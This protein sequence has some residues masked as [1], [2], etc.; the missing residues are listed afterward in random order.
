MGAGLLAAPILRHADN[1]C[2]F[3][4][5]ADVH[6]GLALDTERRLEAFVEEASRRE[7]DFIVQLG[8]FNH[9]VRAAR[10]FIDKWMAYR[11]PRYGVLGNHDMDMGSKSHALDL[12]QLPQRYYS[13]DVGGRHFVVLDANNI[14]QDRRFVHYAD[15]NYFQ[16][17]GNTDSHCDDEQLDW[18]AADLA[19]TKTQT[20]VF[21]HQPIDETYKG[22]T[23]R[24]RHRVRAILEEANQRA[25]RQKVVACFAGH[26]HD[27]GYEERRDIHYFRVNSASYLWVG[28]DYGRM[29]HY[30]RSLFT[31]VTVSDDEITVEGRDAS[32]VSPEPSERGV[33]DA[34]HFVPRILPRRVAIGNG[35]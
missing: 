4:V 6:H 30:D 3:G 32:W 28:A 24:N 35:L 12:W 23:C 33:P 25:G 9:P 22:G 19:T 13:F 18:L 17:T 20:V 1:S 16:A 2:R 29:A 14:Y 21:V 34:G 31:F 26:H 27:D 11:G 10:P 8:D 7:L 15:G 5:I